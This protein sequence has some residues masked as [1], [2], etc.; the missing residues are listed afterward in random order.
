[1][2]KFIIALSIAL[3][4]G[5][6]TADVKFIENNTVLAE[7]L[8]RETFSRMFEG[9]GIVKTP[10]MN[11]ETTITPS[12]ITNPNKQCWIS[13]QYHSDGSVTPRVVCH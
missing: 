3:I 11:L 6:A 4:S 13:P 2:K 8:I 7:I 10:V 1:M 12:F 5:S 9:K